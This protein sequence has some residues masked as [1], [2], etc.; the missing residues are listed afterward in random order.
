MGTLGVFTLFSCEMRE[1]LE[2]AKTDSAMNIP[3]IS[4]LI[5]SLRIG[6]LVVCLLPTTT[7]W[8][9]LPLYYRAI[10]LNQ[11]CDGN[12]QLKI[13]DAVVNELKDLFPNA[14]TQSLTTAFANNPFLKDF[15]APGQTPELDKD[16]IK[17]AM[18]PSNAAPGLISPL[19]GG[20]NSI[21][22]TSIANGIAD[23]MIS[24]A[25]QELTIAFFN[26]FQAY[27]KKHPVFATLFPSTAANLT[28]LL[29]YN[30]PQ[31]LQQLRNGFFADLSQLPSDIE[32]LLELPQFQ[33]FVNKFPEVPI[34][35]QTLQQLHQLES[36]KE[37]AADVIS[38]IAQF[39]QWNEPSTPSAFQNTGTGI[40]LADLISNS[41]R[42]TSPDTV[43][44]SPKSIAVVATD[45]FL[46]KL[47][48]GLL[49]QNIRDNSLKFIH[50]GQ[51]VD[52]AG[53]L[54]AQKS[55]ILLLQNKILQFINLGQKVNDAYHTIQQKNSGGNSLTN[56]DIYTYIG[57]TV[58]V[59]SYAFGVVQLFDPQFDGTAYL[60]IVSLANNVY[61]DIYSQQYTQA[62]NDGFDMLDSINN[63][64]Q[65]KMSTAAKAAKAA[66][67]AA[68]KAKKD[69]DSSAASAPAVT[70]APTTGQEPTGDFLNFIDDL[71][72]FAVFIANMANAKTESDV[73]AA[74][75][76]SILPV[77]SSAVKKNTQCNLAIQSYLGA[78]YQPWPQTSTNG[79]YAWTDKFGVI[80][81]IG[82]AWT[83]GFTS[84]GSCGSLSLF[85]EVFDIGAIVDYKLRV[86][87][88]LPGQNSPTI[89]KNY[90]VQLG[91]IISP[92]LYLVYGCFDNLPLAIGVGG[93]YGP[94]LSKITNTGATVIGNPSIRVNAFLAVDLPL[95]N[96]YNK[97]RTQIKNN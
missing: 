13:N 80:A 12:H 10:W 18:A 46:T 68:K 17:A 40:K 24:R 51:S 19:A 11:Q 85:L 58:D 31:M 22:V 3:A 78:F 23:L 33:A 89:S 69:K 5:R 47:Y 4:I 81:P 84:W 94:G 74:L 67:K 41:L 60:S 76:N 39:T 37:N 63:L 54:E 21:D 32:A 96:L 42:D 26:K 90:S 38:A 82:I 56:A 36:G 43:W 88:A 95:F 91:Q 16:R 6:L 45:S 2:L 44:L 29:S 75:E 1:Y 73:E 53:L 83:P 35:I 92:G 30:Y 70:A 48:F 50:G 79:Q 64:A 49:D 52:V 93:Q 97:N 8:P 7:A 27:S 34:A 25:K 15:L 66:A 28:K 14:T 72:P 77:G 20:L 86:D 87:S 65:L 59:T 71:K 62:I 55:N 57:T 9:Q 61:K